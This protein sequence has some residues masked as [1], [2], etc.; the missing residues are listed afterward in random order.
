MADWDASASSDILARTRY[1]LTS[2]E[3]LNFVDDSQPF[4][5]DRGGEAASDGLQPPENDNLEAQADI[6]SD[7]PPRTSE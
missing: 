5:L 2:D 7:K 4:P 3:H 6:D 1:R